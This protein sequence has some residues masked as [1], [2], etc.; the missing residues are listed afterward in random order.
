MA[1]IYGLKTKLER[2]EFD[3]DAVKKIIG[4]GDLVEVINRMEELL[5]PNVMRRI[6]DSC[7]C[8][9]GKDYIARC[10]KIG[11]EIAGLTLSEKINHIN[12]VSPESER[13]VLNGDNTITVTWSFGGGDDGNYKCVC[14]AAVNKKSK[15]SDLVSDA[16]GKGGRSMP[17]SY[18]YCCA[19]SGRRHLEMQLGV[20]LK[21]KE[22]IS[23]PINGGGENPCEFILEIAV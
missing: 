7:G 2:E 9:G 18:C 20:E 10:K 21:T 17:L 1:R 14:S 6:L 3:E 11:N 23:S 16:D 13:I 19:G 5:E 22:I 8:G 15:V 12:G 4:N